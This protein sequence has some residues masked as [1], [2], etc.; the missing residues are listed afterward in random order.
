MFPLYGLMCAILSF[1]FNQIGI[2]SLF[3]LILG[4]L[5]IK[6]NADRKDNFYKIAIADV[7]VGAITAVLFVLYITGIIQH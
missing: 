5:G 1:L 3:A 7:V 6:R 2:F 4:F